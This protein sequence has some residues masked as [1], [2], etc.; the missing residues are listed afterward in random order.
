MKTQ[1]AQELLPPL[2]ASEEK[3]VSFIDWLTSPMPQRFMLPATGLLIIALDWLLFS[4]E[5][6]TLGLAIPATSLF[7]FLAAS[8]GTYRL[9]RGY[10]RNAPSAS[11]LKALL[12]GVLV[13][14]PFPLAGTFV[15]GWILATSGLAEVKGRLIRKA[16]FR[17]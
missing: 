9:Q 12:A 6:A 11:L 7:G 4:K 15:G 13:G 5:A 1:A 10:A 14:M 3:P 2:S 16:T 17:K 8:I